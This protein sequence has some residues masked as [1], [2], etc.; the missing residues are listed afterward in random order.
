MAKSNA[1]RQQAYRARK[2][3]QCEPIDRQC[4]RLRRLLTD[5]PKM[6]AKF[7]QWMVYRNQEIKTAARGKAGSGE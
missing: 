4:A 3:Q 5:H 6:V 7:E 1:E 2:K